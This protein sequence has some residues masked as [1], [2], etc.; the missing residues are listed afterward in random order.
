MTQRINRKGS[1][2]PSLYKWGH[3]TSLAN[4]SANKLTRTLASYSSYKTSKYL[5]KRWYWID[6]AEIGK[7]FLIHVY[8][9]SCVRSTIRKKMSYSIV[10][11]Q[12]IDIMLNYHSWPMWSYPAPNSTND[13][14]DATSS[15]TR[16]KIFF[17]ESE[18]H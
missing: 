10:L 15:G 5:F 2:A 11:L 16:K 9:S 18:T 3:L 4:V 14:N 6:F 12:C 13:S 1:A 17:E 8:T 7:R